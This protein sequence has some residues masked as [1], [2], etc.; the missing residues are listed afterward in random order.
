MSAFTPAS[1]GDL[2]QKHLRADAAAGARVRVLTDKIRLGDASNDWWWVP[3]E[4]QADP[5][6]VYYYYELFSSI[7]DR[8]EE[9]EGLNLLLVPRVLPLAE[10]AA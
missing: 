9:E 3:V 4:F 5:F 8:L 1:I 10:E 2:V 6:K 7:E